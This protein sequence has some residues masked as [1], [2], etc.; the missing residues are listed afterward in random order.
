MVYACAVEKNGVTF[1]LL[2]NFFLHEPG[3]KGIYVDFLQAERCLQVSKTI[4]SLILEHG[5][6]KSL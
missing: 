3:K 1:E 6:Q 2:K 4:T 5:K